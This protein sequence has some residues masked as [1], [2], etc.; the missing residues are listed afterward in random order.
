M[1]PLPWTA[2]VG[3]AAVLLFSPPSCGQAPQNKLLTA[4][5]AISSP[6]QP[7]YSSNTQ[8]QSSA[9]ALAEVCGLDKFAARC[10]TD[11]SGVRVAIIDS[12]LDPGPSDFQ[13]A[14]KISQ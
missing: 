8:P 4:D 5:M 7:M 13:G 2:A 12:G 14:D 6:F 10:G 9:E 3:L 1:K 11:G